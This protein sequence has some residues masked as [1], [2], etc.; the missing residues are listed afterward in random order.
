MGL[1]SAIALISLISFAWSAAWAA[2]P[3]C[4]G[5]PV[6][7]LALETTEGK[8]LT[9]ADLHGKIT[10]LE[11]SSPKCPYSG[12][13]YQKG[14]MQ[15]LQSRIKSMGGQWITLYSDGTGQPGH[16]NRE[17]AETLRATRKALPSYTVLDDS[18]AAGRAFHATTTPYIVILNEEGVIAYTGTVD[19]SLSYSMG[20]EASIPYAAN[21]LD[22]LEQQRP[23]RQ[24]VT[25]PYGCG[26][27]YA[28]EKS[29][30][31]L[32]PDVPSH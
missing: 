21:A 16:M 32:N 5:T 9:G 31:S 6:P 15:T 29:T 8:R 19:N 4:V 2:C 7:G 18:G 12:R 14:T 22:D 25:R 23:V 20:R 17:E 11:W 26:I 27:R 24:A 30:A 13:Y 28:E 3:A 10:V 1:K